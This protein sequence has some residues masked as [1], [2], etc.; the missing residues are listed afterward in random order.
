MAEGCSI[1][2]QGEV[3]KFKC[4]EDILLMWKKEYI[5][6]MVSS[7]GEDYV[8]KIGGSNFTLK[9]C[10]AEKLAGMGLDEFGEKLRL[11]YSRIGVALSGEGMG[12]GALQKSLV[13]KMQME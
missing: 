1:K 5:H 3:N 10:E 9:R 7:E 6:L 12:P 11:N 13:R 4:K 2:V 8:V